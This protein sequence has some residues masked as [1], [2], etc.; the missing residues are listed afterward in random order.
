MDLAGKIVNK[1]IEWNWAKFYALKEDFQKPNGPSINGHSSSASSYFEQPQ[2]TDQ[3]NKLIY[4]YNE[5]SG[6]GLDPN[7]PSVRKPVGLRLEAGA[8]PA[9]MFE[10]IQ[11]KCLEFSGEKRKYLSLSSIFS[12]KNYANYAQEVQDIKDKK[13]TPNLTSQQIGKLRHERIVSSLGYDPLAK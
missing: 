1:A 6:S 2:Y 12:D 9:E 13:R 11:L 8:N 10:I 4:G 3:I 7:D 5:H